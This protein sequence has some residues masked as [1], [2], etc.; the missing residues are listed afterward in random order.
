MNMRTW[1]VWI[2][3]GA[4]LSVGYL[5]FA[6]STETRDRFI[7]SIGLVKTGHEFECHELTTEGIVELG[8]EHEYPH[9]AGR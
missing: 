6:A 8:L 9:N 1:E 7:A 5:I 2:A 3:L 4:E